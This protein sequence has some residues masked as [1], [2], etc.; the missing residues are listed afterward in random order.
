M[1]VPNGSMQVKICSPAIVEVTLCQ[2]VAIALKDSIIVERTWDIPSFEVE[3]SDEYIT[4][5]TEKLVVRSQN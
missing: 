5:T 3:E 2:S 1:I 4:I